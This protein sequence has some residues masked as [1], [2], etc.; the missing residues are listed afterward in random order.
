M[1]FVQEPGLTWAIKELGAFRQ[2]VGAPR[3]LQNLFRFFLLKSLGVRQGKTASAVELGT[4]DFRDACSR[5][6]KVGFPDD[7]TLSRAGGITRYFNPFTFDYP[8]ASGGSDFAVGTMWTRCETWRANGF[9]EF[10]ETEKGPK[11]R[12]AFQP[13]YVTLLSESIHGK[14]IPALALAAFFFRRADD[15]N[16]ELGSIKA[17]GDLLKL[18]EK[19]FRLSPAEKAQLFD[20]DVKGAPLEML[21]ERQLS[22]M[23]ALNVL[24]EAAPLEEDGDYPNAAGELRGAVDW[25]QVDVKKTDPCGLLGLG[26]AFQRAVGALRSGRNVIF[27]GPPGSGKTELAVC[28]CQSFGVAFDLATATADWTT[29]ETIGAYMPDPTAKGDGA[30]DFMPGLVARALA[31]GHWLV[32][33]EINRADIDKAFGELFTLFSG[34]TV[35]L[36][37]RKRHGEKLLDVVLG[38]AGGDVYAIPVPPDWRIIGTMNTFD[39][40]SLFQLSYAFMRRFAFIDV[41]VPARPVFERILREGGLKIL[42]GCPEVFRE[43]SIGFLKAVFCPDAVGAGLPGAR[44]EVGPAIPLDAIKYIRERHQDNPEIAPK[45]AVREALELFLLPQFE[46][47]DTRHIKVQRA[48]SEALELT[49][50]ESARLEMVLAGWTGYEPSAE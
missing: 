22:R 14:K 32:I 49:V 8:K 3:P 37:F 7:P 1:T 36:P 19:T 12:I 44:A 21:G 11:R 17:G 16:V 33:D 41:P 39:K 27:T 35:R 43:A 15:A 38:E 50:E 20:F 25:P 46:G 23:E 18:F 9:I 31:S 45:V 2:S 47:R 48:L 4:P 40:A 13:S 30:L 24:L 29:Y 5:F 6:L 42:S 26:D 34:K 10:E 28:V